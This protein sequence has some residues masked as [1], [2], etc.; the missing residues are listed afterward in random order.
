MRYWVSA[1]AGTVV[2]GLVLL[3]AA[4]FAQQKTAFD[5]GSKSQMFIDRELVYD[6]QGLTFT[7]HQAKKYSK[8]PIFV[9]DQPCEGWAIQLY[10]TVMYDA[11][12]KLFKMWYDG[13]TS[14]YFSR[15]VTFYATSKDGIHWD[16]SPV[17]TLKSRNGK[18]HN[19][20]ADCL[21]ASVMKDRRDPD[22][23][24]RYKM[25]CYQYDRGYRSM[26]SPDGL[27]WREFAPETIVP[28]SYVDDVVTACWSEPHQV[29]ITF[30][31][32]PTPI[33]GRLRR[34][35]FSSTSHDF[36]HWSK[37]EPALVADRRDDLGSRIR[38]E[39][40]RPI[41][42]YR[43][44]NNVMRTEIYGTGAYA[45]ESCLLTFPW[46]FTVT[47]NVTK[48][49]NHEGPLEVQMAV[50]RDLVQWERPF[51]TSII[52]P[53]QVKSATD[54]EWDSGMFSTAA[55]AFDYQDEVRLYYYGANFTHGAPIPAEGPSPEEK[56]KYR[57]G[58]GLATWKK[59]RFVSVDA[60][61]GSQGGALTTVPVRFS[62]QHLEINA[63]VMPGG[64]ITVELLD[65]GLHPLANWPASTPVAGDSLRHV[66][67]FGKQTDLSQ[68][69]G[70]PVVLRFHLQ[71]AEL[72]AFAFRK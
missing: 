71:N 50:S 32:N 24:R 46:M 1:L 34:T 8:E 41:L 70:Q 39:R 20:V 61:K 10:G 62:G 65:M 4:L 45:A 5:V 27:H 47:A 66:V 6:T 72:Y 58:V 26:V 53:G 12:E 38:A 13:S 68:L 54:A 33:M 35:L 42:N 49:G 19:A 59:D 57:S 31:K 11:D 9:A 21:V 43:D 2:C 52:R 64:Q 44:N 29:F 30:P 60:A 55:Y 40:V 36:V 14:D 18:P 28:I 51:R 25:V 67:Q 3:P 7:Q 23:S 48:I 22:P 37:L 56:K 15:E 63:N 69:A 16:K 17:G